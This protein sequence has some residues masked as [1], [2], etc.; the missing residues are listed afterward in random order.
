MVGL[1]FSAAYDFDADIS[2]NSDASQSIESIDILKKF[3]SS[4]DDL[5]VD[6]EIV[7]HI[8]VTAA[9]IKSVESI[10]AYFKSN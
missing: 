8:L 9:T 6:I 3:L 7:V 2:K 10:D 4:K 1:E 5:Y